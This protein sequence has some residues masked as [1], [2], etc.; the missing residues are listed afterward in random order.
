MPFVNRR[1]AGRRLADELA[2]HSL[3][4]PVVIALPRGGVP[5]AAEV[6][7]RLGAPLDVLVVRKLGCPWQPELGMGAIGEG[8][9]RVLNDYLIA[10]L[11]ITPEHVE[12]AIAAEQA[13][14]RRRVRRYRGDRTPLPVQGRTVILV[15][16]GLATGFT[17]R[18]G[19][20]MLRRRGATRVVLAVPVAPDRTVQELR[21]LADDVVCLETPSFFMA[22]GEWYADFRQTTD[23]EVAHLLAARSGIPARNPGA[24]GAPERPK[25]ASAA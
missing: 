23:E 10:R 5:V 9:V 16:D 13:E 12:A 7:A 20:E 17:A 6:A 4:R 21:S 14:V 3:E 19:I 15:D 25:T 24:P 2:R 1:E 11:Q 8:D 22:I 18:A